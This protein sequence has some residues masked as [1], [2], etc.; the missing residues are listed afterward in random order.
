MDTNKSGTA[1]YLAGHG[2][3][4]CPRLIE[5]QYRRILR[6]RDALGDR[7]ETGHSAPDVFV[8]LTLPRFAMG[9]VYIEEVRGFERLRLGVEAGQYKIVLID[10]DED[11]AF[12]PRYESNFVRSVLERAGA[13][14]LNAFYDDEKAFEQAARTRFGERARAYEVTDSSDVVCFFPSLAS[15]ITATAIR[16]ELQDP[17]AHESGHLQPIKQRIEDLKKLKAY[18][19][20]R[21]PFVE[22]QL[23]SEWR[24][25]Q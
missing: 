11:L 16:K 10:L 7:Y 13:K 5:L 15:D 17:A 1:I 25:A 9:E 8:D 19:G 18:A 6:Y 22:D 20:G 23:S 2:S 3:Q 21:S 14:V 12:K 24:K 4:S